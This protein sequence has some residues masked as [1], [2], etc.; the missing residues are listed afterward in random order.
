[1][2]NDCGHLSDGYHT[3]DELYEHRHQL[4]IALCRR[5]AKWKFVWRAR[6][7][8]DGTMFDGG[9]FILGINSRSG[10]QISYHIPIRLWDECAFATTYDSIPWPFDG[11]TPED[12]LN[13]LR[14]L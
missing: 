2:E 5:L 11:H 10:E 8:H 12:V 7:H 14:D 13:R 1:M 4:F 9:W 6:F 3:F